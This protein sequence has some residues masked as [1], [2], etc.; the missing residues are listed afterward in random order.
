MRERQRENKVYYLHLQLTRNISFGLAARSTRD[1]ITYRS[2]YLTRT[3][4]WQEADC[5]RRGKWKA[6]PKQ[7]MQQ[8]VN[9]NEV[10]KPKYVRWGR[11]N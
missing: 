9:V 8:F 1:S 5:I 10:I 11:V 2:S 3:H 6:K 4:W 7:F